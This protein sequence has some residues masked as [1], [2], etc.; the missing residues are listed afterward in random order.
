M[1]T[2]RRDFLKIAG[3][4]LGGMALASSIES[5]GLVNAFAQQAEAATDYK[6]L[7]CIFLNGGNDGNNM[8]IPLDAEYSAYNSVRGASGLA[9]TQASL[10]PINPASGRQFGFHPNMPEMQTLFNQQKLA[11]VCNTGPL[12]EPITRTTYRDGT[13]KRPLQLFS[14]SDQVNLWQTSVADSVSQT[15]WGGRTADRTATLNGAATFPQLVSIAGVSLFVTGQNT[16]PLA[17]NDSRTS[18]STVLPL[19]MTGTT[20]EIASRRAA[21][22]QIRA[23][24]HG[25][26]LVRAASETR[27]SSLQT[28]Q[29]LASAPVRNFTTIPDT[30]LG[31]Q[32]EQVARLIALRDT[33]GI[34]RQIFFC[35]LG[36]FD[37]HAN[38]RTTGQDTLLQ[39]VSQAMSG[40]YNA[41][42]ELGATLGTDVTREVT[43]FT[44]SDFGRT[45]QPA[46]TGAAVGSDHAWG[47]HHLIMGG[48]VRGGDFYGTYPTLALGGPNDA[49]SR[50]RW[51]PT[52]ATEQYAA[53]LASWY[54]LSSGDM[55]YVF[56]LLNRFSTPNLGFMS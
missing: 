19:T 18:L 8:I 4:S 42:V 30:T 6:A 51:I 54:G 12:V 5:F 27:T 20:A 43:T 48:A 11:V 25:A 17:V 28:S 14:H 37:T 46:G 29:A 33:L 26:T 21:F 55:S 53:T 2:S 38:Q 1:A 16:R 39:H 50:G 31:Y 40:F 56:P 10:R 44:L 47:N 13:G 32:L 24:D 15:G 49:D 35:S 52:T 36:G 23:L 22:D 34:K 9:L 7:V 41:L 3:C 45:F